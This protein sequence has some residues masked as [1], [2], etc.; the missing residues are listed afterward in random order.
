MAKD[1]R[2]G[3]QRAFDDARHGWA[4]CNKA[5]LASRYRDCRRIVTRLERGDPRHQEL[6]DMRGALLYG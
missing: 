4:F 5:M 2:S 1:K 3:A 6:A